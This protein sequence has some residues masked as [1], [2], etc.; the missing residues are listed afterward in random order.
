[1]DRGG[2][3]KH[4]GDFTRS[5][6][7]EPFASLDMEQAYRGRDIQDSS[8]GNSTHKVAVGLPMSSAHS[9]AYVNVTCIKI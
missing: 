7:K 1:M 2:E 3:T 6:P 8:N 5:V 4:L 9:D